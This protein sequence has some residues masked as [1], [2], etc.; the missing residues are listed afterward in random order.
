MTKPP[1]S[2]LAALLADIRSCRICLDA[3]QGRPLP[4]EPR[5]VVRV[6]A[7][8]RI[9]V[10]G[11]APGVRVH[12]SGLPFDDPSGDRL[13]DWM[14]LD[15]EQFYDTGKVAFLPMGFCFP[16]HDAKKGDLPPRRECATLWRS[17]VFAELPQL[18][19]MLLIGQYAQRWHLSQI[20]ELT[21]LPKGLTATVADWQRIYDHSRRLNSGPRILVLPHPSWRNSGWLKRHAWFATDLLPVLKAEVKQAL[22]C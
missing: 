11:Q 12:A 22:R 6:A 20:N 2:S 3:P 7:T 21:T 19:L 18:T 5:P 14:G 8:A 4:H 10:C 17:K 1:E 15:R 13:R 9:A 16:G